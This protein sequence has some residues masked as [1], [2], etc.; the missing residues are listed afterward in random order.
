MK[1]ENKKEGITMSMTTNFWDG[2]TAE[3]KQRAGETVTKAKAIIA[4]NDIHGTLRPEMDT[5]DSPI[6]YFKKHS[7]GT[8]ENYCRVNTQTNTVLDI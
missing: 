3:E 5:P 4:A 1:S 2:W 7:F 6:V 8:W